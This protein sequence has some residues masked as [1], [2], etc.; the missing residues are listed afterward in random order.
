MA[1]LTS[2]GASYAWLRRRHFSHGFVVRF[3]EPVKFNWI[4]AA[5]GMLK[6]S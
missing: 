4:A 5:I 2:A 1:H 6:H 3:A